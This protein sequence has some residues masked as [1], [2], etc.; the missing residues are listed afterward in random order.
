M[1]KFVMT[2]VSVAASMALTS[3]RIS[4]EP[5]K[6][7]EERKAE[8]L[9]DID[10]KIQKMQEHRNCVASA[11]AREDLKKCRDAMRDFHKSEKMERL[12]NRKKGLDKKLDELKK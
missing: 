9:K 3:A 10:E 5:E 4:A 6:N 8:H 12:E 11:A 2:L 7:F 1:N